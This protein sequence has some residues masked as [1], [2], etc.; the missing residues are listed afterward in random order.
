MPGSSLDVL[1]HVAEVLS[2]I[3]LVPVRHLVIAQ[4]DLTAAGTPAPNEK[5]SQTG[6]PGAARPDNLRVL[7]Q[8]DTLKETSLMISLSESG[9]VP[10][11]LEIPRESRS[12]AARIIDFL[13]FF[14]SSPAHGI[15]SFDR[16]PRGRDSLRQPADHLIDRTK[17]TGH[18]DRSG[19]AISR[20]RLNSPLRNS[21]APRRYT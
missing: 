21:K 2:E 8:A 1:R 3:I 6:L 11:I 9:A 19:D 17:P 5:T 4:R 20:P 16:S 12:D 13:F 18:D 15:Q 14:R 7:G 10:T